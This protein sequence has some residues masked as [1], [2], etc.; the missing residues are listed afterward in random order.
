MGVGECRNETGK[1]MEHFQT[2]TIA[3]TSAQC[4]WELWE[5]VEVMPQEEARA[6]PPHPHPL[7]G[8]AESCF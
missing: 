5:T 7:P 8:M 3:G 4:C 6:P 1:G 2:L